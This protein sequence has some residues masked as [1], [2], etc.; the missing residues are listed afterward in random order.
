MNLGT[1]YTKIQESVFCWFI[2]SSNTCI[3]LHTHENSHPTVTAFDVGRKMGGEKC[4]LIEV[5]VEQ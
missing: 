2:C 5:M 4:P 1:D 3:Q